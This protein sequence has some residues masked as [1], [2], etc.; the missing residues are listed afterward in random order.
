M[1]R[2]LFVVASLATLPAHAQPDPE[3]TLADDSNIDLGALGLDPDVLFDDKLQIYGF[4]DFN[5]Q[6]LSSTSP[7]IPTSQ[8][9]YVGNLNLYFKKNI[10]QRWRALSEVRLLFAPNGS[11]NADGSAMATGVTDAA[12]MERLVSWG[13]ISIERAY[14][15][16]DVAPWLSVRAGHWL[17]PY[18]I[19]NIDH[20]SPTII[21][22]VRPYIVGEQFFPEHQTG[23]EAF[24]ARGVG[25]YKVEYHATISNGRN[26]SEATRDPDLRPSVGGRVALEAPWAGTVRVGISGYGGRA[27]ES[28]TVVFDEGAAGIDASWD[29]GGLHLQGEVLAQRRWYVD[30]KRAA[31]GTGFAANGNAWGMYGLA[32]YRLSS[33]WNVMPYVMVER[34]RPF[35][36]VQFEGVVAATAGLNFRPTASVVLKAQYVVAKFDAG[37]GAFADSNIQIVQ[38]QTAWVF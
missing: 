9:F 33:L 4:A 13:G 8:S 21:G 19:W 26:P 30:G 22:T 36:P 31:R 1:N 15:E 14:L 3:P 17:T 38:L 16:Y 29:H 27:T 37:A 6:V 10:T 25:E 20:G 18:G 7:L 2:I 24:G 11:T 12:N 34:Y 28:A 35:D 23:I 5:Y 32:G